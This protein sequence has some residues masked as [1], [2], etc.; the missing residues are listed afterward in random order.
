MR[1]NRIIVLALWILALVGI[2]ISGGPVTYGFFFAV[3]LV[4]VVSIINIIAVVTKYRIHQTLEGKY[5]T[6]NEPIPFHFSLQNETFF[7]FPSLRVKFFTTFSTVND[8]DD[9]KEFEI[10][11]DSGIT[12]KTNLICKYRGIYEVGFKLLEVR[13]LFHLFCFTC[14]NPETLKV[15]IRPK[16][17]D[18]DNLKTLSI[19]KLAK[20]TSQSSS[21]FPDV[22]SREYQ[23]GDSTKLINWKLS[24]KNQKLMVRILTGDTQKSVSII[25]GSQRDYMDNKIFIPLENKL[26]EIALCLTNFCLKKNT[27]V[28]AFY[29]QDTLHS[30]FI[31][32]STTFQVFYD[33]L[34]IM[35]F[36][37]D[38]KNESTLIALGENPELFNSKLVIFILP[39]WTVHSQI[40]MEKLNKYNIATKAY[41]VCDSEEGYTQI[42]QSQV[43][44]SVLTSEAKLEEEL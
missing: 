44:M 40:L 38:F 3:T 26:L 27:P 22:I 36:S 14:K 5:F 20:S 33:D 19:S 12:K 11:P 21:D 17:Y 31:Q 1:K 35:Q 34:S 28:N 32:D 16:L 6:S 10:F 29:M 2:S 15:N 13:D 23:E 7:A 30:P 9:T 24:A 37:P 43:D 42:P 41:I 8:I 25:L 18:L 39:Q 4:P